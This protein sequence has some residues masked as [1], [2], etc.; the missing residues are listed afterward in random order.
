MKAFSRRSFRDVLLVACIAAFATSFLS[1]VTVQVLAQEPSG[2][3]ITFQPNS[4][5]ELNVYYQ[6]FSFVFEYK[7]YFIRVKP[8]VIYNGEYYGMKKIVS[9]LKANYPNVDYKWLIQ[10]ATNA[11]HYGF[12]LTKLPQNVADKIDYL[13]FRLV[14]LNFP[15][16]WFE[17]QEVQVFLPEPYNI[18]RIHVPKANLVFSFEDLYPQGYSVRHVNST[19]VLVG[20]VRGQTDLVVDPI[21]YS[22]NTITVTGYTEGSPCTFNDLWLADKAGTQIL[23]ANTASG[24]HILTI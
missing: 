20:G 13:G 19:Y 9:T 3:N 22:A 16:S 1:S 12:N 4:I 6:N 11:I 15:L 14:D 17:L 5:P 2:G 10:K 21:T 24:N 8:F 7:S 23:L 18:T